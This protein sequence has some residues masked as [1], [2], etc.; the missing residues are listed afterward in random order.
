VIKLNQVSDSLKLSSY[1]KGDALRNNLS[2]FFHFDDTLYKLRHIDSGLYRLSGFNKLPLSNKQRVLSD[3]INYARS[4]KGFVDM[5]VAE[6]AEIDKQAVNHDIYWH[7]K[8]TLSVACIIMFFIGAPFGAIIRKG[9]FGMPVVISVLLY[10][11]FHFLS[12]TGEKMAKGF[13][14]SPFV[15]MWLSIYVLAPVGFFLT[16]QAAND[17]GLFDKSAWVRMANR[18]VH[19]FKK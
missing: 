14:S 3:A 18:V 2:S 12:I 16:F 9:G 1:K 4:A 15:G 11:L 5:T 17:S 13:T 7:K 10:I 19:I 6:K 8:I